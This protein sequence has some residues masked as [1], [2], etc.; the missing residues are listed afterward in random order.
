MLRSVDL[1]PIVHK[2]FM[3]K[4]VTGGVFSV[5]AIFSLSWFVLF[6]IMS[7]RKIEMISVMKVEEPGEKSH[8]LDRLTLQFSINFTNCACHVLSVE[9][10]D[11]LGGFYTDYQ[12]KVYAKSK[13]ELVHKKTVQDAKAV[14][15]NEKRK[16]HFFNK[17][18]LI[19][20]GN[21]L[22]VVEFQEGNETSISADQPFR[23]EKVK[24]EGC[25][26]NGILRT[27]KIPSS[28]RIVSYNHR[29][30][31]RLLYGKSP[32]MS[33]TIGS[34]Q[35]GDSNADINLQSSSFGPL[36]GYISEEIGK[37]QKGVS[38]QY[39]LK[40]V[41]TVYMPDKRVWQFTTSTSYHAGK[42]DTSDVYFRYD[43]SPLTIVN[44][45][46]RVSVSRFV[47]KILLIVG[48]YL[49][50]IIF[51]VFICNTSLSNLSQLIFHDNKKH[52]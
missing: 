3:Q 38:Y 5:L 24:T 16:G 48:A 4:T 18:R 17:Y 23:V 27:Q 32:D 37:V 11:T 41:P 19:K 21:D 45:K 25:V 44:S 31:V 33:H 12:E 28:L 9:T 52:G 46:K 15:I 30:L 39:Y 35:F 34:F 29:E 26:V 13:I 43:F 14:E 22:D 47:A 40:V 10:E 50:L 6:E 20:N 51:S 2:D 49:S 1:L 7:F 42:D 8:L 36:D